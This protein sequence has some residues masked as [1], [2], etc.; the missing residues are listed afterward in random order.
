MLSAVR[1]AYDNALVHH[2]LVTKAVTMGVLVG[3]GDAIAQYIETDRL[4]SPTKKFDPVRTARMSSIGLFGTGPL[5]HFWFLVL[6]RN[7][8]HVRTTPAALKMLLVDQTIAAPALTAFFIFFNGYIE[9]SQARKAAVSTWDPHSPTAT[10]PTGAGVLS[11]VEQGIARLKAAYA[12]TMVVNYCYWPFVNFASFRFVPIQYRVLWN[13]FFG[14]IWNCFLSV[15]ANM[16]IPEARPK[17]DP[18]V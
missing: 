3:A 4:R 6:A 2:P 13:A 5:L 1:V 17:H 14:I 7:F 15:Q 11:P 9:G 18:P 12:K 10:T 8:G 16:T